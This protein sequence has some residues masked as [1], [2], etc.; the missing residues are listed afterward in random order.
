MLRANNEK[1]DVICE[2]FD[3]YFEQRASQLTE[4]QKTSLPR[5]LMIK[6][7]RKGGMIT[8]NLNTNKLNILE[9]I[10]VLFRAF[11]ARWY[12]II[13]DE[14]GTLMEDLPEI[15][16]A[17]K[18]KELTTESAQWLL[19]KGAFILG[20]KEIC[21]TFS[22]LN[23]VSVTPAY[24]YLVGAKNKPK[25]IVL[26]K[27]Q[28]DY[29]AR[30]LENYEAQKKRFLINMGISLPEWY[31][32]VHIYNDKEVLSSRIY[33]EVFKYAYGANATQIK[34]ALSGLQ[35]K[36]YIVKKGVTKGAT[37]KITAMGSDIVNQIVSKYLIN[38]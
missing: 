30:F 25:N 35:S 21:D 7:F 23:E 3:G 15:K 1:Y 26:W 8:T 17:I 14:N 32:L 38:A 28:R 11:K 31:I 6:L 2:G 33:K 20:S 34:T 12:L 9:K 19:N 22:F 24:N 36:G 16:K 13:E 18:K 4:P 29:I 27:Q 37:I 5:K 10:F